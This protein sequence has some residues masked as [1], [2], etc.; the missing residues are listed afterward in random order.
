MTGVITSYGEA[1]H[2]G[3]RRYPGNIVMKVL[4]ERRKTP[5]PLPDVVLIGDGQTTIGWTGR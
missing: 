3:A 2:S 5:T 1:A 4:K